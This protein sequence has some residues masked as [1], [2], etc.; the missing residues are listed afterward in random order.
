MFVRKQFRDSLPPKAPPTGAKAPSRTKTTAHFSLSSSQSW[1]RSPFSFFACFLFVCCTSQS[2]GMP[3]RDSG[4]RL[5]FCSTVNE[6]GAAISLT[7]LNF[8][9][10]RTCSNFPFSQEL[11]ETGISSFLISLIL[12]SSNAKL[13]WFISL[14]RACRFEELI[15]Y[16]VM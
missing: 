15:F 1:N 2:N 16:S 13:P 10:R 5:D 6:P 3:I 4:S 14:I 12:L 11:L 7:F 9:L 8:T